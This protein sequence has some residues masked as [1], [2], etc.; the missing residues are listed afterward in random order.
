MEVNLYFI[1][2]RRKIQITM[3][4]KKKEGKIIYVQGTN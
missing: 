4:L 1:S 3:P 2:V